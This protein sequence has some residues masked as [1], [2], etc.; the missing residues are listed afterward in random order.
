M[1]NVDDC[2]GSCL[3]ANHI[4]VMPAKLVLSSAN[5][6]NGLSASCKT[7]CLGGMGRPGS[8]PPL[9]HQRSDHGSRSAAKWG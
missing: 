9:R 6:I 4:N 5:G 7:G 1:R 2:L 3:L 8:I